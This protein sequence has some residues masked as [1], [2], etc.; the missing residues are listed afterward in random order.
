MLDLSQVW[1][2]PLCAQYLA[3]FGAEV[4]RVETAGRSGEM[5]WWRA[6]PETDYSD[7]TRNRVG[8][9]INIRTP[10]GLALVKELVPLCDVLV[11]NFTPGTMDKLGLSIGTVRAI[12]PTLVI[13]SLSAAGQ[14]GPWRDIR[15][16]GPSLNALYGIK[17]LLG[18]PGNPWPC[19][20]ASEVDP[21]A[22]TSGVMAVM[23][24]LLHRDRTGRG[25]HIDLAMGEVM[26]SLAALPVL[27]YTVN[28]RFAGAEGNLHPLMAPH[29]IYPC[30]GDDAWIAVAVESDD[31]WR[32]LVDLMERP[33]WACDTVLD[34]LE[35]RRRNLERVE[36]GLSDWTR[37]FKP[38]ELTALLQ[39]HGIAAYPVLNAAGQLADRHLAHRR[40]ETI[41]DA[42]VDPKDLIY[43]VPWKLSRT[44]GAIYLP[45]AKLGEHNEYVFSELLG[46][47]RSR[48]AELSHRGVFS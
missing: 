38:Y 34:D 20:D 30:T 10:E 28:H 23:A 18:Y 3:D 29:G 6:R 2:G 32:Q 31:A 40:Q 48:Q 17:S 46:L 39:Q 1:A 45:E 35:G 44:P 25:Q 41:V 19:E 15:T 21:I 43:G 22:G 37:T 16:L 47:E 27:E 5:K 14:T 33:A 12:N 26:L 42:P 4:I 8:A 13:I 7:R 36:S 24:G 9:S 11:E